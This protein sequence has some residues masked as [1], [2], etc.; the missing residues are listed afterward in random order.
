MNKSREGFQA[1]SIPSIL[2]SPEQVTSDTC[3]LLKNLL[4]Q[5]KAKYS[6]AKAS[7]NSYLIDLL[8]SSI[9]EMEKNLKNMGC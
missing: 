9:S 3:V 1:E 8:A 7:N 6:T 5:V 2:K 4:E